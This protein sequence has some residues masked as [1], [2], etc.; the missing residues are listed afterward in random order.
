MSLLE[1]WRFELVMIGSVA[2]VRRCSNTGEQCC[3]GE[4]VEC[5][6]VSKSAANRV[7]DR[8]AVVQGRIR[9]YWINE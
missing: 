4:C 3:G 2:I 7:I 6:H 9:Y 1:D 5:F 8:V